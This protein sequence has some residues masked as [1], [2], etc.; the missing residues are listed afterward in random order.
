M[1]VLA[2]VAMSINMLLIST[3]LHRRR[4]VTRGERQ[5]LADPMGSPRWWS[6]RAFR[7]RGAIARMVA[8]DRSVEGDALAIRTIA[9]GKRECGRG[10]Q[11]RSYQWS[12]G[13]CH[14]SGDAEEGALG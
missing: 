14:C 7:Q 10:I 3:E 8:T 11:R 9:Q 5:Y 6:V 2:P 1:A 4:A 13:V 12:T